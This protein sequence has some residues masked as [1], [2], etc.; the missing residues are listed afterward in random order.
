MRVMTI[1]EATNFLGRPPI[2]SGL[3]LPAPDRPLRVVSVEDRPGLYVLVESPYVYDT[4]YFEPSVC[5]DIHEYEQGRNDVE[6]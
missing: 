3:A 4:D 5:F 2:R 1:A 6:L